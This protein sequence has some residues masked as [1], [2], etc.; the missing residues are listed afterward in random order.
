MKETHFIAQNK[1][2]WAAY[3]EMLRQ[4]Q[5][6]PERLNELFIQI[7]DDLSYARTF[8]PNRSVR[9]YLN[10]MAQRIFHNVYRGKRFPAR[11]IALFWTDETPRLYWEERRAVWLAFGVFVLAFAIGVASSRIDPDFARVILGDGYI[12]MTEENIANGDPMA[13]YKQHDPMG[14]SAGIAANNLFVALR[15]AIFGVLA[16]VGTLFILLYNGIMVGAFQY[17]FIEKG[18]FWESFLTIWIHGTLEIGAIVLA[19][20]SGLVMG[21]GL[22]FPGTYTRAQAF[23]ISMRKGLK[24]F[25]AL[26]P[27]ILLAA[28]F[29]GFLTRF[30]ETPDVIRALF[31]GLSLFFMLG[32]FVWLPWYKANKK[33]F[34]RDADAMDLPAERAE[35]FDFTTIKGPGEAFSDA[36]TLLRRNGRLLWMAILGASVATA[37]VG[38]WLPVGEEGPAFV[39][40]TD[41]LG[42]LH[43]VSDFF[44]FREH[45]LLLPL[46]C[47]LFAGLAFL[48]FQAMSAYISPPD[49]QAMPV[50]KQLLVLLLLALV[51]PGFFMIFQFQENILGWLLAILALPL[52]GLWCVVL[53]METPNPF[54]ALGRALGLMRWGSGLTLGFLL[55]NLSLLL[56]LFLD[57]GV[58]RIIQQFFSWM[59]PP[60]EKTMSAYSQ[61]STTFAA[62]LML[63][64]S[65]VLLFLSAA[66]Q[67][68][69]F[70][71]MADARH[72]TEGI[73]Q[74]GANRQIRGLARE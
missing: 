58:W 74:V 22:L 35:P 55:V 49:R 44:G 52:L 2:K 3:E 71:E 56:F 61:F 60:D 48:S 53:F 68:F 69:S 11:Q 64:F 66:F 29:E 40:Y 16:S 47:F 42:V 62:G 54:L 1:E 13:V 57:S 18:L 19:G 31:I 10:G 39:Y 9:L 65:M 15:T 12:D 32:Y 34:L 20:A 26:T 73:Q 43:G 59:M 67:Y 46:Q 24:M 17:F 27:I 45:H 8:Y 37:T 21:R 41:F 38:L 30:T 4:N 36:F 33:G 70:R 14:M 25:I 23:Q 72:L 50:G 5:R 63:Y 6:N 51:M 7:T 28:F